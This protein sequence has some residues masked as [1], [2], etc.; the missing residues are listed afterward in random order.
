[1]TG[2]VLTQ[3][4]AWRNV[5]RAIANLKAKGLDTP[6]AL[7]AADRGE[8]ELALKPSGYFTVKARRLTAL[9]SFVMEN[10]AGGLDPEVLGLP[11]EELR[12]GLLSVNGVGPE[13]AD[14]IV[15]YAA[16][17]P[18]F[19]VDAYTRRI[20]SRH[21]LIAGDEPYGLIRSLFMDGLPPDA[22]LYNEYH[23]LIVVAGHRFCRPKAPRCRLCPLG[24]D[25]FLSD[26]LKASPEG[27]AGPEGRK[28]TGRGGGPGPSPR[29]PKR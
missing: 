20:L 7:L 11:A 13:T 18:S 17:K 12:E 14:S 15:L 29:P 16:G 25:P 5:E 4:T 6:E 3:N 2:A 22:P 19:V 8:L 1:M 21:S 9:C 27:G 28:G 10:G 24:S 26:G 23:A